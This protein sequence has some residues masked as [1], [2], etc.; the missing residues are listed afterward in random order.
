M[1][2]DAFSTFPSSSSSSFGGSN[3]RNALEFFYNSAIMHR[4]LC[5]S[6][7]TS[8]LSSPPSQSR[9]TSQEEDSNINDDAISWNTTI[10]ATSAA[11]TSV[12]RYSYEKVKTPERGTMKEHAIFGTLW[13]DMMIENYEVFR[14]TM[15]AAISEGEDRTST[16]EQQ[17]LVV[18]AFVK[19]GDHLNGHSGIVH[20]G[21]LSLMFDDL[22]G[23][24][25]EEVMKQN[26]RQ[27]DGKQERQ[28]P[29]TANLNV[30]FRK[31]VL[32]GIKVRM[33]VNLEHREGRKIYWTARMFGDA[34]DGLDKDTL[35][36]E[37][38]SLYIL[39]NK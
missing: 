4:S 24:A 5:D 18:V 6:S 35:Y 19:F 26:S 15:K 14:P 39:V 1:T 32:E 38:T 29:V 23:F 2:A 17:A 25:C 28:I 30:D 37:A 31:P 20:G 36:A 27:S 8:L 9:Q 12:Q 34:D 11:K 22:M 21:I 13:G 16:T 33:E 3:S 10:M 7:S